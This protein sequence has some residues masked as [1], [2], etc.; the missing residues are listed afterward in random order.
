MFIL[1]IIF[2][3]IEIIISITLGLLLIKPFLTAKLK[4]TSSLIFLICTI[5]L[6]GIFYTIIMSVTLDN[7]ALSYWI[8]YWCYLIL[9]MAG[10]MSI[11]SMY[12]FFEYIEY[13]KVRTLIFGI[14]S[15]LVGAIYA[16][17]FSPNQIEIYFSEEFSTWMI[18][19]S[20]YVRFLVFLAG[21]FVTFRMIKGIIV[22]YRSVDNKRVKNQFLFIFFG[23]L[24]SLI[25]LFLSIALGIFINNFNFI[26]GNIFRGSYPLFL[27]TGLVFAIIGF[28]KNPYAV[29]LISQKVFKLIVFKHNGVTIFE[30]E[31][32]P[33]SSRQTVLISGAI[34]GVSSM[35]QTAL[36]TEKPPEIVKYK[37]RAILFSFKG[38]LGFALISDKD[39]SLL[40]NGLN[41]FSKIFTAKYSIEL[42][43]WDGNTQTFKDANKIVQRAFPFFNQ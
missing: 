23:L 33:S 8:S 31:F 40:R 19:L 38:D 15:S 1:G 2:G 34:H 35:I 16:L 39:S 36:G 4:I 26:I 17:I 41:N 22:I 42:K 28:Y 43:N 30:Q 7:Y 21:I 27:S 12:I 18:D 20:Y 5:F 24:I 13:G 6:N 9:I 10:L 14:Y 25:G 32:I 29:Y 11:S 37:N 3:L